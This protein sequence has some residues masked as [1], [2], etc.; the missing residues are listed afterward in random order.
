[1][2]H[3]AFNIFLADDDKDDCQFFKEALDELPFDTSLSI[4]YN[5]EEL[6]QLLSVTETLPDIIFLD[7]NMPRKNGY[8]C[9]SELRSQDRFVNLPII[10]YSTSTDQEILEII[11]KQGAQYYIRKPA[12]FSELKNVINQVLTTFSQNSKLK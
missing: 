5:G 10:I 11:Y 12:E 1:M 6:M 9:L 2:N 7:L 3:T 4:V 8:E